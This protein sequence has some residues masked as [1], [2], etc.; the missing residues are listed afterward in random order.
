MKICHL[1]SV[2]SYRDA[3][4]FT[5]EC[6]SLAAFGHEV[7][8]IAP[9]APCE[10]VNGVFLHGISPG[11]GNRLTRMTG[12][13]RQ[14]YKKAVDVDADVYH[15]HDPELI[16]VG[17][18]MKAKGKKVVYD[19]HE[20]LPKQIFRKPYIPLYIQK[21]VSV[22]IDF[23][24]KNSSRLFDLIICATP[25]ICEHFKKYNVRRVTV[26]NYPRLG[27]ELRPRDE[28]IGRGNYVCYI[29]G[30]SADRGLNVMQE[31]VSFTKSNLYLAGRF[32]SRKDQN[33][34]K[35]TTEG[36]VKYLGFLEKE[37]INELLAN[38]LAGLVVLEENEAFSYSL[39]VK[40]FEYMSAGIPVICSD[41]PL[42]REIVEKYNCGICVDPKNS[43]QLAEAINYIRD[44]PEEARLM[45]ENGLKAVQEE[46]NWE[47]ESK[48]L[49]KA[50]GMLINFNKKEV[51]ISENSN[52]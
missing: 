7:H 26:K 10:K 23:I 41:F 34:F 51:N 27:A 40:M 43:K 31:A 28:Q 6:Q 9:G 44:H 49:I 16:T 14:V 36:Q 39:P 2:H 4:I 20:D 46:Y 38:S 33:R 17:L 3:R 50:Y 5:K 1:T 13:V 35:N 8:L 45:G 29:G 37:Q 24:E 48:K 30:L 32:F 15:F 12:T 18:L 25:H 52:A 42:W 19:V 47:S 21:P 11:K 22:A